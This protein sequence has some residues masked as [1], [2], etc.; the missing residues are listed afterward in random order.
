MRMGLL[1]AAGLAVMLLVLTGT[2]W[3][4]D[5]LACDPKGNIKTPELVE[6]RV[7]KIDRPQGKLTLR[8]DGGKEYEFLAS[9][10]TLQDIKVGDPI[11]AKLREAPQCPEK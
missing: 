6:G 8:G 11:K 7:S 9:N 1:Q 4:Q 10:E 5:K 2:A 3:G